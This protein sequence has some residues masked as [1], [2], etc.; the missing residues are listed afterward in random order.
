MKN[1]IIL[2]GMPGAGKSTIG[3]VLAK[4]L[5]Y[6]FIDSD[7]V[8]QKRMGES[9]TSIINRIGKEGFNQLEGDINASLDVENTV[10]ATG[11]SA[12]YSEKAMKHF[13]SIGRVVF[14]D[15]KLSS[16]LERL[17]DITN[18]GISMNE[19][20][21]IED[22]FNERNILYKKYADIIVNPDE[23]SIKDTMQLIKDK[24]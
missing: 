16:I 1:N 12:V 22:L 8:I 7:I 21:T 14:L 18:R 17:G 2:I 13:K 11:G 10:I 5:G 23:L 4:S 3:V 19:G 20:E 15:L 9:L 6:D 24:L